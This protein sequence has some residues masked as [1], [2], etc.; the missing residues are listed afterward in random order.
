M[1]M[2]RRAMQVTI[3]ESDHREL[4]RWLSAHRTLQQVAQRCRII[5]RPRKVN[6]TRISLRAWR[7]QGKDQPD[8]A[9]SWS[10]AAPN[11]GI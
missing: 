2:T 9:E 7:K 8:L 11:K 6:R 1:F 3:N 10:S 4:E 5:L